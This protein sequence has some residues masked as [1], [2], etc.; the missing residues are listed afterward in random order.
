MLWDQVVFAP[1]IIAAFF[2]FTSALEGKSSAQIC[3]KLERD[4]LPSLKGE[5][6]MDACPL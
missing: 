3:A 2:S 6:K 4:Y 5:L 1:G